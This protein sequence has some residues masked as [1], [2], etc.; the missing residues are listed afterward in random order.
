MSAYRSN[1]NLRC[2]VIALAVSYVVA[3]RAADG[4]DA[5]QALVGQRKLQ[6]IAPGKSPQS[7]SYRRVLLQADSLLARG[8]PTEAAALYEH[9]AQIDGEHVEAEIGL[10]RAYMAAGEFRRAMA[11]AHLAS[12]EHPDSDAALAWL[13]YLEDRAGYVDSALKRL[14]VALTRWPAPSSSAAALTEL[15][16][17]RGR[18]DE[19]G[20]LLAA[21]PMPVPRDISRLTLRAARRIGVPGKLPDQV[22]SGLFAVV[23]DSTQDLWPAPPMPA[24]P[25]SFA[26]ALARGN[27]VLVNHGRQILTQVNLTLGASIVVR[28]GAGQLR[29]ATVVRQVASVSLLALAEPYPSALALRLVVRDP[30]PTGLSP[31]FVMGRAVLV[32]GTAAYPTLTPGMVLGMR[33]KPGSLIQISAPLARDDSGSAVFDADGRL[34]GLALGA[35]QAIAGVTDRERELGSAHF[36]TPS[37]TFASLIADPAPP[38]PVLG[39]MPVSSDELYERLAVAMVE[40]W[41]LPPGEG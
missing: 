23:V 2:V 3:A 10:S 28:N 38:A 21:W 13:A 7:L 20:G 39:G 33:S 36:V 17:D 4:T 16:I 37:A 29:R 26:S 32:A 15:L 14:R 24:A 34:I 8:A 19:A 18:G 1:H 12:G 30:P 25:V 40:V 22:A 6:A 9:A 11:Y 27:G 35:G 5:G 31:C 41:V